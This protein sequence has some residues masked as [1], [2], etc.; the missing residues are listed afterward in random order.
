[1]KLAV[2]IGFGQ[3]ESSSDRQGSAMLKQMNY[4][5][6]TNLEVFKETRKGGLRPMCLTGLTCRRVQNSRDPPEDPI[7]SLPSLNVHFCMKKTL[8]S[9][10]FKE[11]KHEET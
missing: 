1:M 7:P 10:D 2:V 6:T 5:K 9:P 3:P 11:G 8:T 4:S